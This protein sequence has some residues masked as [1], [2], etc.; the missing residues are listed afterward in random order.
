MAGERFSKLTVRAAFSW[1]I[2]GRGRQTDRIDILLAGQWHSYYRGGG[3]NEFVVP[4][5]GTGGPDPRDFVLRTVNNLLVLVRR[6]IAQRGLSYTV[7]A[8]RDMGDDT[9]H[10]GKSDP[11][12]GFPTQN[13]PWPIVEFDIEAN[14]YDPLYDLDLSDTSS[15]GGVT[16]WQGWKKPLVQKTIAPVFVSMAVT[17]ATIYNSPTGRIELTASSATGTFFTYQWDDQAGVGAAVRPLVIGPRTYGCLVSSDAGAS[18]YVAPYVGADPRLEVV[19]LT[20]DTTI[21]LQISGGRPP[22]DV[23][24]DDGPTSVARVGLA[25]AIYYAL[26]TDSRGA[27]VDVTVDLKRAPYHW[28]RNPVALALDAGAAYRLDPTT[29]PNLSFLCEVWLEPDYLSGTFVQV[30]TTLEQPADRQGRTTF[31]V[32]ALLDAY[33]R[34]HVPAPGASSPERAD[35]LFKRFYLRHAEQFGTPPVAAPAL[36]L[37]YRYV[38]QGGLGFYETAARTWFSTYQPQNLPFLTWEPKVKAVLDDQPEFLYYMVLQSPPDFQVWLQVGFTDAADQTL[39]LWQP[40]VGAHNAEV[41]CLPVGYRALGLHLLGATLD[42][43]AW[44]EVRVASSDGLTVLSETRRFERVRR[45]YP[46]R[47]YFLFQTSL[48]SM[49]TY[50][51]LGDAQLDVEVTGE[52]STRTLSPGYDPGEGDVQVQARQLR[53]VL[54]VAAGKRTAAQLRASQDLLL[55]RRVL[56]HGGTRWLPGYLKAKTVTLLDEGK[57]VQV[58][59]FEF[60]QPAESLFTPDLHL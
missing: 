45:R 20:T 11:G 40:V 41:Y 4:D 52:E 38:V 19:A 43:V 16:D 1:D 25:A 10:N 8:P 53:P 18:T 14:V 2:V 39:A 29:K 51:A 60:I 26:I 44:W 22:Y 48:G 58:Q 15:L 23:L 30:G 6:T 49:A 56:L 17:P 54:K 59:E 35:S 55:S 31:D 7:S 28:S 27:Q 57:L 5:P 9:S 34:A 24:W 46:R 47:R 37:D 21:T 32:Q 3:S 42:S 50:A 33:L 12:F 13:Q 36:T